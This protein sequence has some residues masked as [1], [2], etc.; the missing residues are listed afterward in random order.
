[1][2]E[3]YFQVNSSGRQFLY[4]QTT[5]RLPGVNK[6]TA[7]LGGPNQKCVVIA[8]DSS[9]QDAYI[10]RVDYD[11]HCAMNG[12]L[13]RQNGT[14]D[15]VDTALWIVR[16]RFPHITKITLKD[17]SH[18]N[19]E[20]DSK[21]YKLSLAYDYILKYGETWYQNKFHATLPEELLQMYQSSIECITEPLE[22]ID[23]L[24]SREADYLEPYRSIYMD[25]TSP[26]DF[27]N[28][29]RNMY[30]DQY[31]HQVCSW[32][33]KYMNLLHVKLFYDSWF[34][35]IDK[36]HEP[37]NYT[38]EKI[39]KPTTVRGGTRRRRHRRRSMR[40]RKEDEYEDFFSGSIVGVYGDF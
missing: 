5:I 33:G 29:L 24:M 31:C 10:D 36:V 6:I 22:N 1:M 11:S 39:K 18:I 32:I 37:P 7:S 38:I 8:I 19:C 23:Y 40:R 20:E 9:K 35:P 25:S 30:G 15:L 2:E 27:F 21:R 34:I 13:K 3:V 26:R 17:D 16:T 14:I 4:K 28:H 12:T